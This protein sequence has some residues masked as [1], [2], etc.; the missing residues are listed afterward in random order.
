MSVAQT[1]PILFGATVTSVK[2]FAADMTVQK[3]VENCATLDW[4]RV[5]VFASFG[6]VYMGVVQYFVYVRFMT[7]MLFRNAP[8]FA[9][10][11]LRDKMKDPR[12]CAE[13]IAQ[14]ALDQFV[15]MPF[16]FFPCYYLTKELV[17][18]SPEERAKKGQT[19]AG[20]TLEKWK[21]NF[22]DDMKSSWVVWWPCN[23]INFGFMPMHM[24]ISFMAL[25][26]FFFCMILS[27]MRGGSARNA[28]SEQASHL[29]DLIPQVHNLEQLESHLRV[30]LDKFADKETGTLTK[31]GF[32][33]FFNS[34]GVRN[35]DAIASFFELFDLDRTGTVSI[36]EFAVTMYVLAGKAGS[37][38]TVGFVFRACD[39]DKN[40][41]IT[42]KELATMAR[43]MLRMREKLIVNTSSEQSTNLLFGAPMR[44]QKGE[45]SAGRLHV[46]RRRNKLFEACTTIEAVLQAEAEDLADRVFAEADVNKDGSIT[47]EEFT[48]WVK[49]DSPAWNGFEKLFR[50]FEV[51]V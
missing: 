27:V 8:V 39:L 36:Q 7:G 9:A 25:C 48:E 14:V 28:P 2:T 5:T 1:W 16:M 13:V 50:A 11:S 41:E 44:E 26:S 23:I 38:H 24:R 45:S 4:K 3:T 34:L 46:L 17:M 22:M 30:V 40:G 19:T 42:K 21:A 15:H 49:R 51:K 12:G 20:A 37:K 31:E 6:F 33:T 10:K 47:A 18:G 43:S 29:L 32:E 35:S